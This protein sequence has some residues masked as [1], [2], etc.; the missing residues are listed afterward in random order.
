MSVMSA[1]PVPASGARPAPKPDSWPLRQWRAHPLL[2]QLARFTVV[3]LAGTVLNAVLFLLLRTWW[4]TLPAN[5]V[6]LVIST[7]ASTEANRR[8][9][10][11]AS[12]A[13]RWRVQLQNAGTLAF[14]ACYS[15]GVL[16][17]LGFFGS[18]SAVEQSIAVAVASIL[19]GVTRFA[20]MRWWVFTGEGPSRVS[21]TPADV[22]RLS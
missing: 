16:L 19:G 20:V 14:Y 18:P 21:V 6:A 1:A 8:F 17:L 4:D 12:K 7:A 3:G 15:S 5:L 22:E 11:D 9:T 2:A 10:F 13:S